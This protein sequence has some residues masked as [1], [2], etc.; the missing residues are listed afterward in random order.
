MMHRVPSPIDVASNVIGA[1]LGIIVGAR[2]RIR[3]AGFRLNRWLAL[4]AAALAFMLRHALLA[5]PGG[6][7]NT[8]GA[9][10]PGTLEAPWKLDESHGRVALDAS[11]HGLHGRFSKEPTRAA[12]VHGGA[13]IL[14]GATD[15][16][17]FGHPP[18]LRLVGSMT[19][20]AW[21]NSTS[22]PVDDA[23]IVSHHNHSG[24]GYQL[25]TTVD[26]SPRTIG[27]KL[28]DAC[29]R[30]MARYGAT[31]LISGKWYHVAGVYDAEAQTLDVYLN[32]E[33]DNGFLLGSVTSRQRSSRAAV[34]VGR[35]S[36][37]KGFECAGAIDDVRIYT[38]ALTKAEIAADMHGTGID[39]LALRV[40]GRG[41]YSNQAPLLR[42]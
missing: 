28:A 40:T 22:F 4:V 12:G 17:D 19:I 36:D 7:I 9:T 1:V 24:L 23:V 26:R 27:F 42:T 21:I 13:F 32:G 2:W 16:I 29:G 31:P 37:V 3:I 5:R 41:V 15:A 8:R 14:N 20:S 18:S 11:E 39:G 38:F 34:Y 6:A 30:L 25:D 10:S 33:L 35:R